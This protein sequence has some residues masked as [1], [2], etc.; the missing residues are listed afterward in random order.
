LFLYFFLGGGY[1]AGE[2]FQLPLRCLER[3]VYA[4][5]VCIVVLVEVI[6]MFRAEPL[7][8]DVQD[9]EAEAPQ[10]E[11]PSTGGTEEEVGGLRVFVD[12]CEVAGAEV[13]DGCSSVFFVVVAVAALAPC[14][15]IGSSRTR[16]ARSRTA[17]LRAISASMDDGWFEVREGW[18]L[19]VMS[20]RGTS[21]QRGRR[22][23]LL[24]R[25]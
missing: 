19:C 5:P 7:M 8:G 17:S 2:D 22:C 4:R 18:G 24:L 14:V 3:V 13:V 11:G 15:V 25:F 21:H 12:E 10:A 23:W 9:V 20:I 6:G 16:C 1:G